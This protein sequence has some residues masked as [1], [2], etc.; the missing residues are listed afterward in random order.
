MVLWYY[1]QEKDWVAYSEDLSA[2]IEAAYWG[3]RGRSMYY[4]LFGDVCTSNSYFL[5]LQA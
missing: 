5:L 3:K 4:T 2:K 1:Q